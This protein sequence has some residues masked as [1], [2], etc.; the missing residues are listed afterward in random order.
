M[1]D[2]LIS[3]ETAKLA[4]EKGFLLQTDRCYSTERLLFEVHNKGYSP[5]SDTWDWLFVH[6]N[7][8]TDL[9][10]PAPTQSLLQR[11]L[12]EKHNFHIHITLQ[13]FGFGY[14]F[15]IIN[16]SE[17]YCVRN[18]TGGPNHKFTYEEAL[19]AGLQETLKLIPKEI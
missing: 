8:Q 12:R 15:A 18:L 17:C 13:Q 10:F 6:K 2:Q 19:E 11:W 3:F 9:M 7:Y 1:E 14:M 4:K 5:K 16:I